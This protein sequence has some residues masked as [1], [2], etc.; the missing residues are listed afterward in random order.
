MAKKTVGQIGA[1]KPK[2]NQ[3][4][5]RE[6]VRSAFYIPGKRGDGDQ[7]GFV[8]ISTKIRSHLWVASLLQSYEFA[9]LPV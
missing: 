2:S 9:G 1:F 5:T 6:L 4:D 7:D 8:H 3:F